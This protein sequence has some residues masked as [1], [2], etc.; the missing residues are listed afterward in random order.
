MEKLKNLSHSSARF[1]N[2]K[3]MNRLVSKGLLEN[4]KLL[5]YASKRFSPVPRAIPPEKITK[6][7]K[8]RKTKQTVIPESAQQSPPSSEV[9]DLTSA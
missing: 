6:Q 1:H 4:Y 3:N 5:I 7:R 8:P 2:A 9:I